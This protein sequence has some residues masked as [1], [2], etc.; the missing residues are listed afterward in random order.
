[1]ECA[2]KMMASVRSHVMCNV[3]CAVDAA[4]A[5]A[6]GHSI[7]IESNSIIDCEFFISHLFGVFDFFSFLSLSRTVADLL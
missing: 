1:M 3:R 2:K 6:A 4:L 7:N 5:V